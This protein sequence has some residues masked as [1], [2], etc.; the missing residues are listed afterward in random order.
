MHAPV[1]ITLHYQNDIIHPDSKFRMGTAQADPYRDSVIAAAKT[2]LQSARANAVPTIHGRI[3]FSADHRELIA[4]CP[5]FKK[6]EESGALVEGTWGAHFFDGLGPLQGEAVLTHTRNNLFFQTDLAA[7]LDAL[8][9]KT[10][11]LSGIATSFSVEHTA[12]HAVDIGYRVVIARD[13][14]TTGD[15]SL[16]EGS[17]RVLSVLAD[18]LSVNEIIAQFS[19]DRRSA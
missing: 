3:A 14:C 2:L 12:R 4:N 13:A 6:I 17:L 1:Y 11:I 5:L 8:G 19:L 10:L 15:R 16:H 9:A 18:I 7:R